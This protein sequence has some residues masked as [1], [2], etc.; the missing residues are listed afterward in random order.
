MNR[1]KFIVKTTEKQS[2]SKSRSK[3]P[4]GQYTSQYERK[5]THGKYRSH[6]KSRSRSNSSTHE[7]YTSHYP[8]N[9]N[10]EMTLSSIESRHSPK[11]YTCQIADT[12]QSKK[13]ETNDDRPKDKVNIMSGKCHRHQSPD[14]T[15]VGQSSK[16][17]KYCD[18]SPNGLHDDGHE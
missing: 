4:G 8:I 1:I 13:Y 12:L 14:G 16:S 6:S 5:R 9:D 3:T 7:Q 2:K 10:E 17:R 11:C 18:A 15:L